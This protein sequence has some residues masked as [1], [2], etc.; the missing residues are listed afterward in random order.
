[1]KTR[2]IAICGALATSALLFAGCGDD[3]DSTTDSSDADSPALTK[4]QFVKA[5]NQICANGNKEIQAETEAWAEEHGI[6]EQGP[7]EAQAAEAAETIVIPS[8]SAQVEEIGAL[9]PP[10]EEAAAVEAFVENA[11]SALADLEDEPS[12]IAEEPGPFEDVN[13]EAKAL[14]LP[15]CGE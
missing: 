8:V 3:G 4:G 15:A 7:S 14:G 13:A 11:E 10:E 6:G 2:L 9:T 12:A 1:M 5:A